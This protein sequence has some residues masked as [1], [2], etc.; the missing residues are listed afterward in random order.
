MTTTAAPNI[1]TSTESIRVMKGDSFSLTC[2]MENFDGR[3]ITWKKE[4]KILV[5]DEEVLGDN[6]NVE[7][8]DDGSI[9]T[10]EN[11]EEED[12]GEYV[13]H[14]LDEELAHIVNIIT[15]PEVVPIPLS[16]LVT[17]RVADNVTFGCN[18]TRGGP[19]TIISWA[20]ATQVWKD[21]NE[22]DYYPLFWDDT[23][24]ITEVQKWSSDLFR[25]T[26]SNEWPE[27]AV[28]E[29]RL[30]V[31]YPPDVD[32]TGAQDYTWEWT[33]L[34]PQCH[35]DAHPAPAV[36]W[37]KDGEIVE[38]LETEIIHDSRDEN[39]YRSEITLSDMGLG[40]MNTN[41]SW[42][43]GQD[44]LGVWECRVKNYLGET[45]AALEVF[46]S[47]DLKTQECYKIV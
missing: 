1:L 11:A 27:T 4:D 32:I 19:G 47:C 29:V 10:I 31:E 9:I 13:C 33:R 42:T 34:T 45:S 38:Y 24:T 43:I 41:T 37:F 26:A 14:V 17:A 30:E 16:G 21:S 35:I 3:K 12:G 46:S 22:T 5:V 40:Y 7:K 28:A 39:K 25:C 15:K 44:K 18:I 36:E 8:T 20:R 23:H 6:I 2:I